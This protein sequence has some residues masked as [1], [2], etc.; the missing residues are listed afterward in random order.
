MLPSSLDEYEF[1]ERPGLGAGRGRGGRRMTV[2]PRSEQPR[3][4][5]GGFVRLDRY[6]LLQAA[7]FSLRAGPAL[8]LLLLIVAVSLTTPIFF[9]SRN[10]GNVFSQTSVIAVLALGQLLVIVTRG[11]DLSVGST[12]ALSGVVGAVVFEHTQLERARDRRDPRHRRSRSG[13]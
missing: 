1:P 2:A 9:T 7:L 11:I 8:I 3:A 4:G 10:I 13:S 12:I 5:R 6:R